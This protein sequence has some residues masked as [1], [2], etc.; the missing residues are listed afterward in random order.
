MKKSAAA[1]LLAFL[2]M[3]VLAADAQVGA[4]SAPFWIGMNDA[5]AFQRAM[6]ARLEHARKTL[7]R[8]LAE[9]RPASFR[10]FIPTIRCGRPRSRCRRRPARSRPRSH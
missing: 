1:F 5:G 2:L 6:D 9:K 4:T 8:L 10:A 7:D 3:P